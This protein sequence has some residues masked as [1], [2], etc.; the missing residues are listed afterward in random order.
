MVATKMP[1]SRTYLWVMAVFVHCC[2]GLHALLP[3]VHIK[4]TSE[5]W[6]SA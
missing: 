4:S 6:Q 2:D 3:G 1:L 5:I